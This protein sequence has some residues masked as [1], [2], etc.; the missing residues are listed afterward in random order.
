MASRPK[1]ENTHHLWIGD[2]RAIRG[3]VKVCTGLVGKLDKD[4]D[5][6]P[7]QAPRY[8]ASSML[9]DTLQLSD[10]GRSTSPPLSLTTTRFILINK[11]TPSGWLHITQA[12]HSLSLTRNGFKNNVRRSVYVL[13]ASTK[14]RSILNKKNTSRGPPHITTFPWKCRHG[15]LH[16]TQASRSLSL[17]SD[18]FK[19]N[20]GRSIYV[21]P[22]SM[23]TRL[24]P[25]TLAGFYI[26]P[27]FPL[28]DAHE[29]W[30]PEWSRTI[31]QRTPDN[32]ENP[33]HSEQ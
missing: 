29:Q 26:L 28:H 17:T 23:K 19:N 15:L 11:N 24:I 2:S 21:L 31:H 25:N 8:L 5:Y 27:R 20:V 6:L 32:N 14:T 33:I 7:I 10:V 13:P 3:S 30:L 16:N 1:R 9:D 12:T 4:Q 22:T 18:G